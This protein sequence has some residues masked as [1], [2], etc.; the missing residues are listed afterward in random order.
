MSILLRPP[1]VDLS[2]PATT[3]GIYYRAYRVYRRE[4]RTPIQAW[5]L[6]AELTVPTGYTASV[7]EAQHTAFRDYQAGWG[8]T[9]GEWEAGFDYVVTSVDITGAEAPVTGA[10]VTA[11]AVTVPYPGNPWVACNLLPPLSCPVEILQGETNAL[12]PRVVVRQYAGRP[13]YVT[14]TGREAPGR[15][16]SANA[17]FFSP[18]GSYQVNPL[19]QVSNSGLEVALLKRLGER[20]VGTIHATAVGPIKAAREGVGFTMYETDDS[21]VADYNLPAGIVFDGTDDR[22]SVPTASHLNPGTSAFTVIMA[23]RFSA[24]ASKYAL[25]KGNLGTADG[26]GFR[27]TAVAN[28]FQFFVDGATTSGGP[29]ATSTSWFDEVRVAGGDSDGTNQTL[30]R[31]GV[32]VGT[33]SVTH[34]TVTNAVNLLV[35]ANN[36]AAPA[37]FAA[38]TPGQSVA[39][40]RRKLTAAEHLA[41]AYYLKGYPGYR[42]PAGAVYCIDLRDDR[43]WKGTGTTIADLSDYANVSTLSGSPVTRGIP[44][45]LSRYETL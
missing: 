7:V 5:Q 16:L 23:A 32:Q 45:T 11:R 26:Y 31:D 9:G 30:Y 25:S 13:H 2:W 14:I 21:T 3:L 33:S 17:Q 22:I 35:G 44:W 28:E 6:I 36:G 27:T 40:Y 37:A 4:S 20:V 24:T 41:A 42:L 29:S 10:A 38:M 39:I 8:V 1:Y 19:R 12:D 43:C 34:G 15:V 18:V